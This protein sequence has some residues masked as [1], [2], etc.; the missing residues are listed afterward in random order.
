MWSRRSSPRRSRPAKSPRDPGR[1]RGL[2]RPPQPRAAPAPRLGPEP[3]RM[4]RAPGG[5]AG[6]GRARR[7]RRAGRGGARPGGAAG[8]AGALR[9]GPGLGEEG[10][11]LFQAGEGLHLQRDPEAIEIRRGSSHWRMRILGIDEDTRRRRQLLQAWREEW[12]PSLALPSLWHYAEPSADVPIPAGA[13]L[14]T[15]CHPCFKDEEAWA[16]WKLS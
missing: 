14:G 4:P 5:R 2:V 13:L 8:A 1:N 6:S 11:K 15:C 16:S 10:G 12:T 9:E 3:L 7:R